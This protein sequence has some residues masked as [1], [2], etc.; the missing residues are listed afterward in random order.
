MEIEKK[1]LIPKLPDNLA[2]YPH[3]QIKQGYISTFPVIRIR[4]IDNQYILTIKG[5]GLLEREEHELEISREEFEHLSLKVEGLIIHKT[6]YYIAY[7]DY[8]IE[9]DLFHDDYDGLQ[10]AEVEFDTRHAAETFIPPDWFG[11]DVTNDK[12]YHNSFLSQKKE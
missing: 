12:R 3:R 1:Y 11:E 5:K 10:L 7:K 2:T 4:Q 9:L 8:T 6:R